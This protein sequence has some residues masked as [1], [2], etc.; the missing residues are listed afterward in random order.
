MIIDTIYWKKIIKKIIYFIFLIISIL[1]VLKLAYF[2]MPFIIALIIANC[3][4]PLIKIICRKTKIVRKNSAKI[5]LIVIFAIIILILALSGYLLTNETIELLKN[6]SSIG[7]NITEIL[8]KITKLL[9][10]E[11]INISEEVKDLVVNNTNE[12]LNYITGEL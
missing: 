2:F 1:V 5:A 3:I 4:E 12:L 7:N 11:N 9:R 6:F 10:L 8:E